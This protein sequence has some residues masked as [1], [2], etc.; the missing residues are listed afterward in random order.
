MRGLIVVLLILM[1]LFSLSFVSANGV[2]LG[3]NDLE[4]GFVDIQL[5]PPPIFDNNT[6]F[7]NQTANWLTNIGVLTGVNETQH[8][9]V[10][11]ELTIKE[12]WLTSFGNALWCALTGCT[13]QGDIDMGGFNI[14]NTDTYFGDWDGGNVDNEF[15]LLRGDNPSLAMIFNYDGAIARIGTDGDD[16]FRIV[17]ND[18]DRFIVE[19][20]GDVNFLTND[21]TTTGNITANTG[22]LNLLDTARIN[23]NQ[24]ISISNQSSNG[25]WND[26]LTF[27]TGKAG[28][29][30]GIGVTFIDKLSGLPYAIFKPVI[31]GRGSVIQGSLI[32]S[33]QD[34]NLNITNSTLC[35]AHADEDNITLN[36]AC[37]S[38]SA[39]FNGSGADL[40]I[41]GDMQVN[42]ELWLRDTDGEFHFFSREL[43]IR[44]EMTHNTTLTGL[45]G[46]LNLADLNLTIETLDGNTI[47]VNI[48]KT[49][50]I[51]GFNKDS[52][53]LTGGTNSSPVFNQVFYTTQGNPVLNKIA[54]LSEAVP[55][56]A[57]YLIGDSFVYASIVGATTGE[58]FIKGV[59]NRFLDDGAIYKS[60]FD[61]NVTSDALNISS[62]TMKILLKTLVLTGSQSTTNLSIEI[63][64][65]GD[66]VQHMND[67]DGYD[68]YATGESIS[69]NKYFNLVCG[70]VFTNDMQGRLFCVVQD[71]PSTEHTGVTQAETDETHVNFFPANS[72]VQKAYI[73]IVRIIVQST[74]SGNVIKELDNTEMFIDLRGQ[75]IGTG[76][77]PP[78]FG[79]NLGNHIMTEDLVGSGFN[80]NITGNI[81]GD[82]LFINDWTNLTDQFNLTWTSTFNSTYDG[83]INWTDGAGATE[84]FNTTGN[85]SLKFGGLVS[86]VNPDGADAIRI[87]GTD[88]IDIVIGSMTGLF[89]VWNVADTIPVFYVDERGDTDIA[90]DLITI[91]DVTATNFIG[92]GSSLT[93]V[94][95]SDSS[96][97]GLT[98]NKGGSFKITTTDQIKAMDLVA[99]DMLFLQ[100]ADTSNFLNI[101]ALGSAYSANKMLSIDLGNEDRTLTFQGIVALS[102]VV[103]SDWFDQ[104][105][106]TTAS[107]VH[108]GMLI[109]GILDFGTNEITDGS[110]TGD[111]D[112][113]GGT[114]TTTDLGTFG[115]LDVKTDLNVTGTAILQN[116]T[117]DDGTLE[118]FSK[119]NV[120]EDT[121]DTTTA[122]II[123]EQDG[124]G[125]ATTHYLLTGGQEWTIGIDNSNDDAFT[126]SASNDLQNFRNFRFTTDSN[127]IIN[128][129]GAGSTGGRISIF[130]KHPTDDI[131]DMYTAS[132]FKIGAAP[133]AGFGVGYLFQLENAGGGDPV[134]AGRFN[135]AWT[136]PTDTTEQS[137]FFIETMLAG[138]FVTA[139]K[140]DGQTTF[141]G[142]G[143]TTN[144]VEINGTGN[145]KLKGS[146]EMYL[147]D[148]RKLF[149]GTGVDASIFYDTTNLRLVANES[150]NGIVYVDTNLSA[151]N[152]IDRTIFWEKSLG[153]SLDYVKDSDDYKNDLETGWDDTKLSL[154][155]QATYPV[156]DFDKPVN[157]SY[158]VEVCETL[159]EEVCQNII[160]YELQGQYYQQVNNTVCGQNPQQDCSQQRCYYKEVYNKEILL[161]YE[162]VCESYCID[163]KPICNNETRYNIIYPYKKNE[164][165]RLVSAVIGKHEQNIFDLIQ[166]NILMKSSLCKLGEIVWC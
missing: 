59:Y 145:I 121:A 113:G 85:I 81:T 49:N 88:Y 151:F 159:M 138:S 2:D 73:P 119:I 16:N 45:N 77:S 133:T 126:I 90:G 40:Y 11:G 154:F 101:K 26:S 61:I 28:D 122:G 134:D 136:D 38:S 41:E 7:V 34:I 69:T 1:S 54:T 150:G 100:D 44:D 95:L 24:N 148:D 164:T 67:L 123:V 107:P 71:N 80:I 68:T 108:A 117:T 21:L 76:G 20:D 35:Q 58:E 152:L 75:A 10:L 42:Q 112:F 97:T 115:N 104:S 8:E 27:V 64:S 92:N 19:E 162:E 142:D 140:I 137:E 57:S 33:S 86:E 102:N 37:N 30:S 147:L 128:E 66:F 4:E 146:A 22:F 157:E 106:K 96:Q 99:T 111:W 131:A 56:V 18:I 124:A 65:A 13:M 55:G 36:I 125:D 62:G 130:G 39:F 31:P 14:T 114:L 83:I 17:T 110:M 6:A 116:I 166:E 156:T 5:P 87:K 50:N 78:T 60:G 103:L 127:F 63:N 52:I 79:D 153:S 43:A 98:G 141:I 84:N 94:W 53:I 74:P 23:I 139:F 32:L 120:Y 132:V 93:N 51:L 72:I 160:S 9:N 163:K 29:G 109:N 135:F 46:S 118:V 143:G 12:S 149:L 144:Y 91:G 129:R 161:G 15:K 47:V 155:E 82:K 158:E 70:I 89:A 48:D 165:G 105:V 25:L 3:F